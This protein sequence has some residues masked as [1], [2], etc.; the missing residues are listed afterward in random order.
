MYKKNNNLATRNIDVSLEDIVLIKLFQ[1]CQ[2]GRGVLRDRA[3]LKKIRLDIL[4]IHDISA[5]AAT[6]D[7]ILA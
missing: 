1:V 3:R 5:A 4:I 7:N 6:A 2:M